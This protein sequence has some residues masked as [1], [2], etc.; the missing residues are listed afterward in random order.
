MKIAVVGKMRSGKDTLAEYFLEN[1][2]AAKLAFG[3]EIKRVASFYFPEIVR[4]G[5]PRKL[6]QMI[7]QMFREFDP[8]IWIKFLDAR[9]IRLK[10]FGLD[11]NVVVSDVRQMN[12]YEYLKSRGF[13][14]IKVHA[15]DALRR[16]R[17]IKAGD[18]VNEE[19]FNHETETIVD[20]IPCDFLI[21]NNGTLDEF[22]K[23]IQ[24]V[25]KDLEG[26]IAT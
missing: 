22:I 13:I 5:K 10:D 21:E 2:N 12:E 9:L 1:D 19:D 23:A 20:S 11:R 24:A 8:N 18:V 14:V 16:E 6:Y 26:E 25:H 3:D 7:G 17:I 15:D 4:R